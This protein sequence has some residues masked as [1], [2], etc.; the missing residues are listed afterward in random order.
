M[1][2]HTR[3][4]PCAGTEV[5][6][7]QQLLLSASALSPGEGRWGRV[8]VSATAEGVLVI[9]D[10]LGDTEASVGEDKKRGH[11]S[12]PRLPHEGILF[13]DSKTLM[14]DLNIYYLFMKKVWMSFPSAGRKHIPKLRFCSYQRESKAKTSLQRSF[15]MPTSCPQWEWSLCVAGQTDWLV[16]F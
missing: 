15:F 3:G 2:E 14:V 5:A 16:S 12:L 13:Y 8:Y 1:A 11:Q 6:Q 10:W 4:R 7:V 9:T